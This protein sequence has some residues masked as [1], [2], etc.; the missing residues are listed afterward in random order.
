MT[1]PVKTRKTEKPHPFYGRNLNLGVIRGFTFSCARDTYPSHSII[2]YIF[3]Y[4]KFYITFLYF[5]F[6]FLKFW[7]KFILQKKILTMEKICAYHSIPTPKS[8]RSIPYMGRKA[9]I[10]RALLHLEH[11]FRITFIN[12]TYNSTYNFTCKFF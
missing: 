10:F 9:K 8:L 6:I 1:A 3:G 12:Y 7:K 4:V 5:W 2:P 11:T